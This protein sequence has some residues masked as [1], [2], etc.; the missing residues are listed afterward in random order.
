MADRISQYFRDIGM[1]DE[2]VKLLAARNQ[3][4]VGVTQCFPP[5]HVCMP[6]PQTVND[7]ADLWLSSMCVL[8]FFSTPGI[9][10]GKYYVDGGFSA[11]WSVPDDQ[12]WA[13]V[14]KVT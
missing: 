7:L 5:Q 3:C 10:K 6:V 2:D 11:A 14:I 9:F 12:P 4:F 8:P 13:D 1:T